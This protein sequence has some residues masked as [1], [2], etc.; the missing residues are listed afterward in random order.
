M[1]AAGL[2]GQRRNQESGGGSPPAGAARAAGKKGVSPP[3]P[4]SPGSSFGDSPRAPADAAQVDENGPGRP[5]PGLALAGPAAPP[6][7]DTLAAAAA[8]EAAGE[9][10]RAEATGR[11][12]QEPGPARR[13]CALA[14]APRC[15]G[16]PGDTCNQ[17]VPGA[18]PLTPPLAPPHP[19]ANPA[20][21]P[22]L[23]APPPLAISRLSRLAAEPNSRG[24]SMGT[25][26]AV[27]LVAEARSRESKE[28]GVYSRTAQ[29]GGQ[30]R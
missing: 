10:E 27:D 11:L 12:C 14:S 13:A 8:N 19:G 26:D 4:P 6:G 25:R 20:F 22:T 21:T 24:G 30:E 1:Q 29:A 17:Q 9:V 16:E 2:R 23:L 3:A 7:A 28:W 18:P 5:P 15:R